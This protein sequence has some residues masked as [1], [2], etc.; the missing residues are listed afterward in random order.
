MALIGNGVQAE[1]QALA[2]KAVVGIDTIHLYYIY[3]RP[4]RNRML[5]R[6]RNLKGRLSQAR[7]LHL[8]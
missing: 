8:R 5:L 6:L 3:Y 4:A 1:F 2:M 7:G